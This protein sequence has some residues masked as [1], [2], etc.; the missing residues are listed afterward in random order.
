MDIIPS[1]YFTLRVPYHPDTVFVPRI[2]KKTNRRVGF[3]F[4]ERRMN[5]WSTRAK[6]LPFYE[7]RLR[8]RVRVD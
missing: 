3:V 6:E 4:E 5:K 8:L 7:A 2:E 1:G